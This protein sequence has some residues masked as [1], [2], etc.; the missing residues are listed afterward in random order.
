MKPGTILTIYS[1]QIK[2]CYLYATRTVH[3]ATPGKYTITE[4]KSHGS[5]VIKSLKTGEIFEAWGLDSLPEEQIQEPFQITAE[6]VQ[7]YF[8]QDTLENM[9]DHQDEMERE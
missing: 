7:E 4:E 8:D 9:I 1:N 3:F 2:G 5:T 6:K